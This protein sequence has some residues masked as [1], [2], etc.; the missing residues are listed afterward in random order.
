MYRAFSPNLV[1]AL[2]VECAEIPM[3][4]FKILCKAFPEEWRAVIEAKGG[5]SFEWDIHKAHMGMM[6]MCSH[7][8]GHI[9]Y[10]ATMT[11]CPKDYKFFI[12]DCSNQQQATSHQKLL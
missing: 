9:A 3:A 7:T 5:L 10:V 12:H 6:E 4:T 1:N 2:V 11:S 8:F